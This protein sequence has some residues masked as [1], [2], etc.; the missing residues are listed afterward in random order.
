MQYEAESFLDKNK[1][2]VPDEHLSL[3]QGSSFDYLTE[4]LEKAAANN[5][6]PPVSIMSQEIKEYIDL[7][8]K[9]RLR[10]SA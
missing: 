3:L 8:F 1:D 6:P 9:L 7:Y 5:P 4:V 10:T 2:T